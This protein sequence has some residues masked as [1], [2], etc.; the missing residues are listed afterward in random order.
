MM[1][2]QP[3]SRVRDRCVRRMPHRR[4]PHRASSGRPPCSDRRWG[5]AHDPPQPRTGELC[6]VLEGRRPRANR[7]ARSHQR[8]VDSRQLADWGAI[9]LKFG[10]R[11]WVLVKVSDD[12]LAVSMDRLAAQ[13]RSFSFGQLAYKR[14][15]PRSA[16]P[17]D[18]FERLSI[19]LFQP[20]SKRLGHALI[21][22]R[23]R[24]TGKYYQRPL[25]LDLTGATGKS[26]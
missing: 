17:S 2:C 5:R 11:I 20:D 13:A 25:L 26:P 22:A 23:V 8:A 3:R 16:P 9:S 24:G 18:R 4:A 14:A 7:R 15:Q 19:A 10:L 6:W 12:A 21:V 1:W